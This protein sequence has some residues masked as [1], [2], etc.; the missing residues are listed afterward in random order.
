MQS[1]YIDN[2]SVPFTGIGSRGGKGAYEKTAEAK[3]ASSANSLSSFSAS[4][5]NKRKKMKRRGHSDTD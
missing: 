3:I 4:P 5:P 1:S 2:T